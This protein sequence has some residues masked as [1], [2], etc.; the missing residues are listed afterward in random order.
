V[1]LRAATA[2]V[3]FALATTSAAQDGAA[4]TTTQKQKAALIERLL[5]DSPASSRIAASG[6]EEAK[7]LMAQAAEHYTRARGL[8]QAG[9]PGLDDA[10][11]EAMWLIG[12]ARQLVPDS[13]RRVIEERVR[14]AQLLASI[15]SLQGSYRRHLERRGVPEA[16][17][18]AWSSVV[19]MVEQAKVRA[20][21]E[22]MS[23]ANQYLLAAEHTL[24][25]A[26]GGLLRTTT[27]DYTPSFANAAEE[28]RFELERNRSFLELV[29]IAVAEY[30][31]TPEAVKLI[32]RYVGRGRTLRESAQRHVSS[33]D[34]QAALGALRESTAELQRALLAAGLNVPRE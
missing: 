17:D 22:Q 5:G 32:D 23:E 13:M 14:Y 20:T 9:G 33:R 3:L 25:N 18:G 29:P 7:R 34:Y 28:A 10:L 6:N 16:R 15:D 26:F 8:L 30:R 24:L 11:N 4:V 2:A 12:K 1:S 19:G 27:L 21:A 31:P